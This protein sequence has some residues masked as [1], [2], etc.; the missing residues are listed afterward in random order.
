[1]PACRSQE[2]QIPRLLT[3]A[4]T[5]ASQPGDETLWKVLLLQRPRPQLN[6][7]RCEISPRAAVF[8]WGDTLR[9]LIHSQDKYRSSI[10]VPGQVMASARNDSIQESISLLFNLSTR[11]ASEAREYIGNR[12]ASWFDNRSFYLGPWTHQSAHVPQTCTRW[13]L[14]MFFFLFFLHDSAQFNSVVAWQR[15]DKKWTVVTLTE[16]RLPAA[17]DPDRAA[18]CWSHSYSFRLSEQNVFN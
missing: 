16:H 18:G 4:L 7:C 6:H 9:P 1:M 2:R 17:V 10:P 14:R 5:V 12:C 13:K 15:S 3:T 8:T 11:S